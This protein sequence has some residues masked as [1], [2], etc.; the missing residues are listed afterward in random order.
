MALEISL[1]QFNKIAS[2][3]YNAGII[4]FKSDEGGGD[5]IGE[6]RKVNNH[7]HSIEKNTET[8]SPERVLEV[9]ESFVMAMERAQVPQARI[10]EI[11]DTLGI[12]KEAGTTSDKERL[13]GSSRNASSL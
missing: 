1:A 9:K 2:G 12:P 13:G 7:V 11:R 3:K 4:D 5:A 6:L 10:D 8:L